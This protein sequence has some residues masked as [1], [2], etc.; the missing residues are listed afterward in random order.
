MNRNPVKLAKKAFRKIRSFRA[1]KRVKKNRSVNI[2]S[3]YNENPHISAIIQV[4]NKGHCIRALLTR[5]LD[6]PIDEWIVI[7]DGSTDQTLI[8]SLPLLTGKN[9]FL[10]KSNDLFEVRTYDR[11]LSMARGELAILLQDDDG[12]PANSTWVRDAQ[13]LFNTDPQ[14]C[15]LGGRDG[16]EILPPD[17]PQQNIPPIYTVQGDIAG[18]AGLNKYRLTRRPNFSLEGVPFEYVMAINRS[19]MWV[20]RKPFMEEIG[21][22]QIFAPFLCDDVDSCLRAWR[23][24]WRV[25]LYSAG[26][27]KFCESGMRVFNA[28]LL[29]IQ[30]TKNWPVVYSRHLRNI[31][32]NGLRTAMTALNSLLTSNQ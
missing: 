5:L 30:N 18:Q 6:F 17:E 10:L 3:P 9:H 27:E 16:L 28:Q 14:L 8:E 29:Q 12:P 31:E 15:I 2:S 1:Q 7:D 4:F 22:D 25:G 26:F 19:P 21:I 24:G 11:A 32:N 13:H 20:R 23:K